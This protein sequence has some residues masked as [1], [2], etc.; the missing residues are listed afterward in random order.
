MYFHLSKDRNLKILSPKIPECAISSYEDIA[1][2]RV[3][4]SNTIKGCLSALQ[5]NVGDKFYVYTIKE[6]NKTGIYFPSIYEVRDCKFTGE[7][8]VLKPV[9]VKRIGRI[10]V[11][12]ILS[13]RE[14]NTE[15]GTIS[16]FDYLF[17]EL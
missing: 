16:V 9:K 12:K 15:R 17:E 6:P 2:K 11:T 7:V 13:V 1:S 3:C 10:K 8:W 4:F 5:C 14:Y